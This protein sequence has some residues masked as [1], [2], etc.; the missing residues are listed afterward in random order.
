MHLYL[1]EVSRSLFR[2]GNDLDFKTK[3]ND[4]QEQLKKSR[5]LFRQGNDLDSALA[6]SQGLA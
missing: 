5:S 2:Q 3:L 4:A 1:E 6:Y